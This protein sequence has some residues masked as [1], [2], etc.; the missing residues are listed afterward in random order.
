MSGSFIWNLYRHKRL[1][2]VVGPE[3]MQNLKSWHHEYHEVVRKLQYSKLEI[4]KGR[5][6]VFWHLWNRNESR[7]DTDR[8]EQEYAASAPRYEGMNVDDI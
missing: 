6:M 4:S 8:N 7:V 3:Y 5:T 2:N 1:S